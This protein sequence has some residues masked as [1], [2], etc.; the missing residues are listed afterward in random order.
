MRIGVVGGTGAAGQGVSVRLAAAGHKVLLG[1]RDPERAVAT[2]EVLAQRWGSRIDGLAAAENR[3]AADAELVVLAPNASALVETASAHAAQ[4]DGTITLS[5][6][7]ALRKEG[8]HFLA[9][10]PAVGSLAVEVQ[11]MAPGA[12]VV[13]ALQHVAASALGDLDR[14]LDSDVL[15]V[16]DDAEACATV[17]S[18]VEQIAGL[19]A[20]DG[21]PLANAAGVETF[22]AALLT[23][24]LRYRVEATLQLGGPGLGRNERTAPTAGAS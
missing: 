11:R 17:R 8:R 14:E 6:G 22:A 5:M 21:G 20:F 24:N 9:T 1:S 13:A 18:L 12:R 23:V 10:P 3:D 19:R 2:V 16:G 7:S 15:V 4:L